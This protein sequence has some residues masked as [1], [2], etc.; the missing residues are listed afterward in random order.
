MMSCPPEEGTGIER[1]GRKS[2][3][4]K[5]KSDLNMRIRWKGLLTGRDKWGGLATVNRGKNNIPQKGVISKANGKMLRKLQIDAIRVW[6]ATTSNQTIRKDGPHSVGEPLWRKEGQSSR[7]PKRESTNWRPSG[8][9]LSI[10]GD[11]GSQPK[12]TRVDSQWETDPWEGQGGFAVAELKTRAR[13]KNWK[14]SGVGDSERK[15]SAA[16]ACGLAAGSGFVNADV[17]GDV[18]SW[19][20]SPEEEG[21]PDRPDT[22]K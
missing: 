17:Q 16:V 20:Q 9:I 18:Q 8:R 6:G 10:N 11:R 5:S 3:T 7:Q 12:K 21:C 15:Y 13:H 2:R 14:E 1:K 19:K 4:T 22:I